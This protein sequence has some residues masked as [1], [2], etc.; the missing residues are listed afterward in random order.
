MN[1]EQLKEKLDAN[2]K[3]LALFAGASMKA[4]GQTPVYRTYQVNAP[5]SVEDQIALARV[6]A[7]ELAEAHRLVPNLNA[8]ANSRVMPG[9]ETKICFVAFKGKTPAGPVTV[10]GF[11]GKGQTVKLV[12]QGVELT[13]EQM[14]YG[15][16]LDHES[17]G[18]VAPEVPAAPEAPAETAP[19]A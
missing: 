13:A 12:A 4:A 6:T 5:L 2:A 17:N 9:T 18:S 15:W 8:V 19:A 16:Y 3:R 14:A 11:F 10:D 1:A 7:A